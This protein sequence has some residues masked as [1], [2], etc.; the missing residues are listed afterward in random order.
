MKKLTAQDA[1]KPL[2]FKI[3]AAHVNGAQCKD[4]NNCVVA[5]AVRAAL[6]D[7]FES[8]EVGITVTKIYTNGRILRYATPH[9]LRRAIPIFDETKRWELP[10]GEYTLNTVPP[11]AKLGARGNRWGRK[12]KTKT[13]PGKDVMKPRKLPTRTVSKCRVS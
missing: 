4:P 13:A 7:F 10:H 1:T 3:A 5:Q 12:S 9:A 2:T 11:Q 8:I 6:G